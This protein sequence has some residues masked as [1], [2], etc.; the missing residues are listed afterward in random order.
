MPKNLRPIPPPVLDEPSDRPVLLLDQLNFFRD[1][2]RALVEGKRN[3]VAMFGPTGIGKTHIVRKMIG[4]LRPMVPVEPLLHATLS[5]LVDTV[6]RLRDGGIV[7]L[8]DADAL[9]RVSRNYPLI[10]TL[11]APERERIVAYASKT[12]IRAERDGDESV[13]PPMF[14]TRCQFVVLSNADE[15]TTKHLAAIAGRMESVRLSHDRLHLLDYISYLICEEDLLCKRDVTFEDARA[16]LHWLTANVYRLHSVS[17]TAV[18][19]AAD[20]QQRHGKRWEAFLSTK[21]MAEKPVSTMSPPEPWVLLPPSQRV[22]TERTRAF[23]MERRAAR[24]HA[25]FLA[26]VEH[27]EKRAAERAGEAAANP[28]DRIQAVMDKMSAA[29]RAERERTSAEFTATVAKPPED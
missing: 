19:A 26:R 25:E 28:P 11:F 24:D 16:I 12:A 7:L 3:V 6:W 22:W 15:T 17:V 20:A 9:W 8:D 2:L 29:N 18:L 1:D 23:A 14:P 5:A 10:K 27:R 21:Y 4:D 13:P